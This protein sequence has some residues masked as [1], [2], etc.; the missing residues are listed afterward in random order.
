TSRVSRA[1]VL[2][3]STRRLLV[4]N[5]DMDEASFASWDTTTCPCCVEGSAVVPLSPDLD[6][7]PDRRSPLRGRNAADRW[8]LSTRRGDLR[9]GRVVGSGDPTTTALSGTDRRLTR[10]DHNGLPLHR[11]CGR[12][13]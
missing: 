9:S 13:T 1:V 6:T 10:P 11:R 5:S 12:E 7:G 4:W 8:C 3:R 2:K